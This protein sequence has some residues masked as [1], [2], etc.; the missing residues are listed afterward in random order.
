M[1]VNPTPA[2]SAERGEANESPAA[3]R[4]ASFVARAAEVKAQHAEVAVSRPTLWDNTDPAASH[5]LSSRLHPVTSVVARQRGMSDSTR[6]IANYIRLTCE[7]LQGKPRGSLTWEEVLRY[8][9]HHVDADAAADYAR[10]IYDTYQNQST[11]NLNITV[12]RMVMTA[13]RKADLISYEV[14]DEI[15][16]EVPTAPRQSALRRRRLTNEDVN[17]LMAACAGDAAEDLRDAAV[18]SLFVTTGLRIGELA[19]IN[20]SDWDAVDRT[21]LL[22]ETKNHESHLIYI[23]PTTAEHLAAW[24][25][26]RG[27]DEPNSALFSSTTP[28]RVGQRVDPRTVRAWVTNRQRQAGIRSL[29]THDFRRQFATALLRTHDVSLVSKLMNH[30]H[31]ASTLVYDMADEV[32]MRA[33]IDT[34]KIGGSMPETDRG[35]A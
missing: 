34:V 10:L 11:R 9:W 33:A 13:C 24:C 5:N 1:N 12:L 8:P 22:R 14:L 25:E 30:K 28:S 7:R 27:T 20:L 21:I 32:E 26:L 6:F 3:S 17:S 31:I 29:Q 4:M 23:H 19:N 2:N 16:Q 35:E 15:L 18:I